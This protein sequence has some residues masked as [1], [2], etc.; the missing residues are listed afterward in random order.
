MTS[1][2]AAQDQ[3]VVRLSVT[4]GYD[5][6]YRVGQW[7]PIMVVASNDG[8][9]VRGVL[10]WRFPG[11]GDTGLFQREIDLPRGARKQITLTAFSNSFARTGEVRL[12][13]AGTALLT[14]RVQLNPIDFNEFVVGVVS[15]DAS[16]LNSLAAMQI[17]TAAGTNVLHL[18]PDQL[19]DDAMALAAIDTLFIHDSA[20]AE[21]S[22]AQIAAL[23]LWVRLGGQLV[24][25][26]GANAERT[27]PGLSH[28]L[29]VTIRGLVADVPLTALGQIVRRNTL[30]DTLPVSATVSSV[31]LRPGAQA[32][33]NDQLLTVRD[34]GAGRII[35]SAFDLSVLRAWTGEPLL[36]SRV[37]RSEPLF[38]P[39][40]TYRWQGM[41]LL[42]D[43]LRLPGL[44]LP[45]FAVLVLFI[46]TYILIVG[47][48]NFLVLRRLGRSEWAWA[49][50]PV[51]VL[52]FVSGTYG[53]SLLVRGNQPQVMQI[54]IVQ[55]FEDDEHGQATAF[56]GIF[57]PR[58]STYTLAFPAETLVSMVRFDDTGS[59][60]VPV[61]WADGATM[62]RDILVD[63]SSLRTFIVE[64]SVDALPPIGSSLQREQGRVVGTVQNRS[65]DSL[66]DVLI[67]YGNTMQHLGT[68][69]SG[70]QQQITLQRN[71][72]NFPG[73]VDAATQE[74]F[75]RQRMLN[76]LFSPN[77]FRPIGPNDPQ[78]GMPDREGVYLLA[79]RE[80]PMIDTRVDGSLFGQQGL[81]LY[82][83]RL[84]G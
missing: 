28:L 25:G 42:R 34:L 75:N 37:L 56:V 5:S 8:A 51:I 69:Q 18:A 83:I 16:L 53:A 10:E 66:S 23:D 44:S 7:F 41:N 35:F 63:V 22:S 81:T 76:A 57:S 19:P 29:P 61:V 21:L 60:E 27:V 32:L 15:S 13:V 78:Q 74:L 59:S 72:G 30:L 82:V 20:T 40:T 70:E 1:R 62:V 58:R 36:W 50:I 14:E 26:G 48:F 80:Q 24:V 84:D 9:D 38:S 33:D 54:A 55:G 73:Q 4:A 65:G 71:A 6:R 12:L 68:L 67:V 77:P 11:Q 52:L 2:V 49:T 45:S 31:S 47:P 79:W 17:G 3:S 39:A 46:L 43:V 64:Q